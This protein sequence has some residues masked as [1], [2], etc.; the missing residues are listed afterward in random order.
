MKDPND[1]REIGPRIGS[2]PW[3]YSAVVTVAG[4]AAAALAG[5][6]L[7]TPA[8]WGLAGHGLLWVIAAL[9]LAGEL[10]PLAAALGKPAPDA[11]AASL[12]FC[13]AALL[14]WGF[15][16]AVVLRVGVMLLVAAGARKAPLRAAFEA[17]R[18]TLA[19]AA[20]AAVLAAGRIHPAPLRPWVPAGTDLGIVGLAAAACFAVSFL[21]AGVGIALR[22]R[23]PVLATLRRTLPQAAFV[24]LALLSAAP[25]VVVAM[26]RSALFVLL[27]LPPLA[28]VYVNAV[29][30]E[31]R[32]H[33]A[34][35]DQ[36]TGL[37]NRVL[38]QRQTTE[39]LA[40]ADRAGSKSGFLLLDL[41][42]F[43]EVNDTLGHPL[44]D[45]L[46]QVVARRLSRSVRPGDVV[47]RLGGDEFAV[48]L[49][50]VGTGAA[51]REV[52][53]R[54][55]AALAE[56]VRLSG[57]SLR[58]EASVGIALYPDD[59]S[60]VPALLQRADI[61]MYLA[62]ERRSGV[63]RYASRAERP[64]PAGLPLLGELRPDLGG[65]RPQPAWRPA[66]QR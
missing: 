10:K 46:L 1:S 3:I 8:V 44:G 35:H 20:A 13:F 30:S 56:P 41:D 54:L 62:K 66:S 14:Y 49:P 15:P 33:Q 63:E 42:R 22:R 32:Q 40:E 57:L 27:F 39:A 25:L 18:D 12:T 24:N 23:A 51:A 43:K 26:S 59:G 19:L 28:A 52:A 38:L 6:G 36:L 60:T 4:L 7:L 47:A 5:R 61:A 2:P 29:L 45:D 64:S 55:R 65:L 37:P 11:G 48:L 31:K 17:A 21:L 34:L 50:A 9:A 58:I 16:A 53:V